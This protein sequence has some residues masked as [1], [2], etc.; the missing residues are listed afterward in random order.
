MMI[1]PRKESKG[2][3]IVNS[4]GWMM[5]SRPNQTTR[6]D[7]RP[8]IFFKHSLEHTL[9][10]KRTARHRDVET[11]LLNPLSEVSVEVT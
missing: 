7:R 11:L 5:P 10:M 9:V 1:T 6:S 8:A 3:P 4:T 2:A